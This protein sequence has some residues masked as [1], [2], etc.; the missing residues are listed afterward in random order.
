MKLLYKFLPSALFSLLIL[1]CVPAK[2]LKDAEAEATS[3]KSEKA[4]LSNQIE[5]L[6]S[7]NADLS[8]QNESIAQEFHSYRADCEAS[9]KELNGLRQILKEEEEN[10]K[11]VEEKLEV[12]LEDFHAGGVEVYYRDGLL[13]VQLAEELLYRTGSSMLGVPGKNAL[14]SLAAVLNE[15]PRLRVIV[16]GNTDNVKYKKA[17]DNWTLSTER[18]NGVVRLLN[19]T[20]NVDASRLTSAGKAQYNPVSDNSTSE[21]RGQNRRIDI[22]LN[23][24]IERIWNSSGPH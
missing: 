18:A 8:F 5:I 11:R 3:L 14:G 17:N 23:P 16:V 12:A 6:H 21:G 1:S 10:L 4:E 19:E 9:I 15:Y 24:D 2:K 22:I 13:R 7:E 20:Y